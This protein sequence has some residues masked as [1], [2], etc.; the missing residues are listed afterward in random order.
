MEKDKLTVGANAVW[1][2]PLDVNMF[3]TK[4]GSSNGANG[5]KLLADN[6][7]SYSYGPITEKAKG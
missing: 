7:P 1:N 4:K 6:A 3:P 5:I 2:G